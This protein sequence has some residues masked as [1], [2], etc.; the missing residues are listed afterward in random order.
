MDC[1]MATPKKKLKKRIKGYNFDEVMWRTVNQ[2]HRK[3]FP[4]CNIGKRRL[5]EDNTEKVMVDSAITIEDIID[6]LSSIIEA[7]YD[8]VKTFAESI[9]GFQDFPL[10]DRNILQ[11]IGGLEVCLLHLACG[12]DKKT[13]CLKVWDERWL[14]L[15]KVYKLSK[16]STDFTTTVFFELLFSLADS[17]HS[18]PL[19]FHDVAIFSALLLLPSDLQ[20]IQN[21]QQVEIL[22]EKILN[23][24]SGC[25]MSRNKSCFPCLLAQLLMSM[26]TLRT[27]STTYLELTSEKRLTSSTSS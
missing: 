6:K 24:L 2:A 16:S 21:R 17:L 10:G 26:P 19:Q 7:G 13:E 27:L 9:P 8:D 22:Q 25:L 15:E 12:F 20:G 11:Q 4:T 14:S 18:L 3:S 1:L 23:C 5:K